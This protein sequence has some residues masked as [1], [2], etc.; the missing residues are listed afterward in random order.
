MLSPVPLAPF[1]VLLPNW[2][3]MCNYPNGEAISSS[4]FKGLNTKKLN[5]EDQ[6]VQHFVIAKLL[7]AAE[8]IPSRK[9]KVLNKKIRYE[10]ER[11]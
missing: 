9:F 8:A 5:Q 6:N 11:K 7:F 10:G 3:G 2:G 1:V 4:E